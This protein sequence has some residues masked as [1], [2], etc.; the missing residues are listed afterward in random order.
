[1]TAESM[2]QMVSYTVKFCNKIIDLP[3]E[4]K[5]NGKKNREVIIRE[6]AD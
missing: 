1:M 3:Q 6:L 5:Q 2:E 4:L